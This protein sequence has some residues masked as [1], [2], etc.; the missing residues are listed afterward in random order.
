MHKHHGTIFSYT[1]TPGLD[2]WFT[3]L[4]PHLDATEDLRWTRQSLGSRACSEVM[5]RV[6]DTKHRVVTQPRGLSLSSLALSRT[7]R[8][9]ARVMLKD[10]NSVPRAP[11]MSQDLILHGREVVCHAGGNAY[12]LAGSE[13][14]SLT[15]LSGT[16]TNM[17][18]RGSPDGL[19]EN[20]PTLITE[21]HGEE[22]AQRFR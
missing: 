5:M 3:V 4:L 8:S 14:S 2:F 6:E 12:V 16:T 22:P 10:D 20:S 9:V 15:Q 13:R 19:A 17:V 11:G 21:Q 18:L 1:A 7:L